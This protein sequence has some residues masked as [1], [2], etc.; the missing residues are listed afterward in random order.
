[1]TTLFNQIV[2]VVV[3]LASTLIVVHRIGEGEHLIG[4]NIA[5]SRHDDLEEQ[6][7]A[8]TYA[9]LGLSEKEE[10]SMVLWNLFPHESNT[11]WWVRY[12]DCVQRSRGAFKGW[13][14]KLTA[15]YYRVGGIVWL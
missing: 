15:I 5:V 12:R 4:E 14:R 1:M 6:F 11:A 2:S 13:D 3:L 8:A 9:R 7:R 10:Q